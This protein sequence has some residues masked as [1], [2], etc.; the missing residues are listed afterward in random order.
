MYALK[1]KM[2][3]LVAFS[4]FA[5]AVG[6]E[7]HVDAPYRETCNMM[8]GRVVQPHGHRACVKLSALLEVQP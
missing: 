2:A 1:I 4:L 6:K 5:I 7:L 8:G 3:A